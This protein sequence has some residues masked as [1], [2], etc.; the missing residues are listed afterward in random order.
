MQYRLEFDSEALAEW[1]NLDKG[2]REAL[3][4][5]LAKRLMNP[6]VPAARLSADLSDC[7]KVKNDKTGHR[8]VYVVFDELVLV[9]VLAVGKRESLA[10]YLSAM[11]RVKKLR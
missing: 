1:N 3:K 9:L 7:Y 6:R 8:L 11:L 5:K 4:K 10:V 2:V